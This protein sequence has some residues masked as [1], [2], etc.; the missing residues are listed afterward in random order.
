ML[1]NV[2]AREAL[3]IEF[4]KRRYGAAGANV[5]GPGTLSLDFSAQR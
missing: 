5:S 2:S 1:V 3:Q 4:K